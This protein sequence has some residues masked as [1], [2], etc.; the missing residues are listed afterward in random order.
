MNDSKVP[1][2]VQKFYNLRSKKLTLYLDVVTGERLEKLREPGK[3][4]QTGVTKAL[5]IVD[6]R[7]T[8]VA[9][10]NHG[11]FQCNKMKNMGEANRFFCT[12]LEAPVGKG[13]CMEKCIVSPQLKI[14]NEAR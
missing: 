13:Y 14:L 8:I 9:V 5:D 12:M 1:L 10:V 7:E 2:S 3:S 4:L 6:G 11:Q